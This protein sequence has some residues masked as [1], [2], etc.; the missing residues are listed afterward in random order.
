M[1]VVLK[2]LQGLLRALLAERP[3]HLPEYTDPCSTDASLGYPPEYEG[4]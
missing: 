2:F 4:G 3:S 1:A